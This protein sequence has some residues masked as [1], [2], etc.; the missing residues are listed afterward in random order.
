MRIPLFVIGSKVFFVVCSDSNTETLDFF[1]SRVSYWASNYQ[2]GVDVIQNESLWVR[3]Y[4]S[5]IDVLNDDR[6]LVRG[7][8]R[9][10]ASIGLWCTHH[11]TEILLQRCPTHCLCAHRRLGMEL[12]GGNNWNDR[13]SCSNNNAICRWDQ[14]SSIGQLLIWMPCLWMTEYRSPII[15]PMK[16]VR[17]V[18]HHFWQVAFGWDANMLQQVDAIIPIVISGRYAFRLGFQNATGESNLLSELALDEVL[19]FMQ[20]SIRVKSYQPMFWPDNDCART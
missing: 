3:S 18:E 14:H 6:C 1:E 11:W 8:C 20:I 15:I 7:W 10:M 16:F 4:F 17:Q 19:V 9:S 5:R 2:E 12:S 13:H